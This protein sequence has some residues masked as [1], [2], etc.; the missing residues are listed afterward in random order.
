MSKSRHPAP[1]HSSSPSA[2]ARSKG[3]ALSGEQAR[4]RILEVIRAIPVGEV[5]GYGEVAKRAGLPGRARLVARVLSGNDDSQL[6]WHR[7]LRSDGRIALPDGS[8][9][10]R[11]QCQRL[12]A[13][14]VQV[15]QG[16]VRRPSA[17]QRLDAAVWGPS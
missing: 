16:R 12:R 3:E 4:L 10:Y 15:E 1:R 17:A 14:G 8:A 11:E 6:P 9:G 7:V 13:E 2:R 5:A